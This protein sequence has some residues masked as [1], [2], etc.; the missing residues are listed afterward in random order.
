VRQNIQE[1]QLC[2]KAYLVSLWEHLVISPAEEKKL[3]EEAAKD[4]VSS[5]EIQKDPS[6]QVPPSLFHSQRFLFEGYL[7]CR[8]AYLVSLWEHLVISPAEEKKLREEAAKKSK[9]AKAAK[10][11]GASKEV[12]KDPSK[13]E[14]PVE[15]EIVVPDGK[16]TAATLKKK[17]DRMGIIQPNKW[18]PETIEINMAYL[19]LVYSTAVNGVAAIHSNIIKNQLFKEFSEVFGPKFQ[20]KTNGVT[21]RRCAPHGHSCLPAVQYSSHFS[22]HGSTLCLLQCP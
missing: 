4:D 12:K 14:V 18:H 15:E 16:F 9:K 20:N 1:L 5:K 7:L 3:R 8:K 19:A 10:D 17:V 11:E 2:R 21:P 13:Q 22:R 6:K